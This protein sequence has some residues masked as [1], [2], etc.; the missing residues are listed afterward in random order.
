MNLTELT[1]LFKA[2]TG[3]LDLA[4]A[5][6]LVYLNSGIKLLD[7]L[8]DSGKRSYRIFL[9]A[10]VGTYIYAL[11]SNFR[12]AFN[13]TLHT[14]EG[15]IT[16]AWCAADKLMAIYRNDP[17]VIADVYEN[18]FAII[19][20]GLI[21]DI[22]IADIPVFGDVVG[23]QAQPTDRNLYLILYPKVTESSTVEVECSAYTSPLS[24]TNTANFWSN[25]SPDLVIQSCF[26]LLT[27][28]LINTDESTKLYNDLKVSVRPITFDY[29]QQEHINQMEG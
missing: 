2:R 22:P 15:S 27:K 3:R 23:L 21:S 5:E 12:D 24:A 25:N 13:A 19:N 1:A 9:D 4:D 20:S 16:L 29:Y 26:Y 7:Q 6:I 10:T 28:D 11:P 18:T 8:E 17:S 14:A